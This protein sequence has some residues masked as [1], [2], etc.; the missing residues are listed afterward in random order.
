ME[1]HI[2]AITKGRLKFYVK[3]FSLNLIFQKEFPW[4]IT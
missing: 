1:N 3:V 2:L 4:N